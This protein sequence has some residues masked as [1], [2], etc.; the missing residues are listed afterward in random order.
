MAWLKSSLSRMFQG[1]CM[2]INLFQ[3]SP[4]LEMRH[5][6]ELHPL[7]TIVLLMV[8]QILGLYYLM[9]DLFSMEMNLHLMDTEFE[10]RY[11]V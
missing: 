8:F 2:N 6:R 4:L 10:V 11:L 5:M 3:R 1:L 9:D 7:S